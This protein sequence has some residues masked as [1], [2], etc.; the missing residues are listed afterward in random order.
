MILI[1]N[2]KLLLLI[3]LYF[4]FMATVC[5][6]HPVQKNIMEHVTLENIDI[7]G[8]NLTPKLTSHLTIHTSHRF[9]LFKA[10]NKD[11]NT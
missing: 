5:A 11:P 4:A 7:T 3:L 6:Q 8:C 10:N 2:L 1:R 9:N